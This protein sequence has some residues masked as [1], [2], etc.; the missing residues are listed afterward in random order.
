MDLLSRLLSLYPAGAAL[1]VRCDLHAPWSLDHAQENVGTVPYHLIVSGNAFL[2]VGTRKNIALQA[3]VIVVFPKGTAHRLHVGATENPAPLRELPRTQFAKQSINDDTGSVTDILCGKFQFDER[4]SL[5]LLDA[6]PDFIVVN[7]ASRDDLFGLRTLLTMLRQET[8]STQ[9]GASMI[10]SQLASTLFALVI[11][12]WLAQE[13][14]PPS[15]FTLL[16]E[17]RLQASVFAMLATP[18]K[19]W[20]LES[21][22]AACNMSRANFVRVFTRA[23]GR[24]PT[25]VLLQT[26]MSIAA[27][28]LLQSSRPIGEIAEVVGY[29]SEAAFS[30]VFKRSHGIGPGQYRRQ[31]SLANLIAA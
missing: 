14:A 29:Q 24:S 10:V 6:L 26:R 12:A 5:I 23:A 20:T 27:Q 7:A 15:L 3:G 9:P 2:D 17:P 18:E 25:A 16:A 19:P 28:R 30:R 1:N 22:A 11:R 8:D 13:D 4:A 31:A 21:M